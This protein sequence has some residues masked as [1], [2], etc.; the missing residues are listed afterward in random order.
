MTIYNGQL[1]NLPLQEVRRYAGLGRSKDFPLDLLEEA[2]LEI[3]MLAKPKGLYVFYPYDSAS[4]TIKAPVPHVLQGE[5]IIKHLTD[6]QEIALLAVTVGEEV[7]EESSRHFKEG[8]Y[9]AGLLLDAAA[10]AAVEHLAD[11]VDSYVQQL[12]KRKGLTPTWRFSP[13]YGDW[14]IRNQP[15]V[16]RLLEA[17]SIGLICNESCMLIPRKSV[18]AIIGLKEPD[19]SCPI[20]EEKRPTCS[21]CSQK[22]CPARKEINS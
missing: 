9:T 11:Q 12:A 17:E 22:N 2:S 14:D 6:C 16:L 21:Q 19:L 18:T 3:K 1:T 10:T 13:G 5:S 8:L 7:E 20:K 4:H 15:E